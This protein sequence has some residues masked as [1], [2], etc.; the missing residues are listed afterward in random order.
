MELQASFFK[1]VSNPVLGIDY[2]YSLTPPLW[3]N[4]EV[5]F[6]LMKSEEVD[7]FAELLVLKMVYNNKAVL[8]C[9]GAKAVAEV[10]GSHLLLPQ[11]PNSFLFPNVYMY[12]LSLICVLTDQS[13]LSV[14]AD[15]EQQWGCRV[16]R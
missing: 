4:N 13:G 12:V 2:F 16:S 10:R 9:Y 6:L 7:K 11:I 8:R 1:H 5:I 15:G 3:Q 14:P